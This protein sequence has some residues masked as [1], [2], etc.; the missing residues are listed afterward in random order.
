MLCD[1][2]WSCKNRYDEPVLINLE[3]S[4]Y[5]GSNLIVQNQV[6]QI[7]KKNMKQTAFTHSIKTTQNKD[8]Y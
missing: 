4:A 8:I 6:T 3:R 5:I 7:L 1:L 2:V